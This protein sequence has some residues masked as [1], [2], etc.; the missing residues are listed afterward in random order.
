MWT[1]ISVLPVSC[2][3]PNVLLKCLMN[4]MKVRIRE[5]LSIWHSPRQYQEYLP[6]M[7]ITVYI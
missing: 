5:K 3:F 1:M 7:R 6:L 2:A 4:T